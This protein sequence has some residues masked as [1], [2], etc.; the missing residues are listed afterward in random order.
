[1]DLASTTCSKM[2]RKKSKITQMIGCQKTRRVDC[3][4]SNRGDQTPEWEDDFD[5]S[6]HERTFF[7]TDQQ[8]KQTNGKGGGKQ[9][10]SFI[11]G[12]VPLCLRNTE[13]NVGSGS[14]ERWR[15]KAKS[16]IEVRHT[17]S[18]TK[19]ETGWWKTSLLSSCYRRI[20]G[21]WPQVTK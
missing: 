12:D 16:E 17:S 10:L 4:Q 1:M 7:Y 15:R 3:A 6:S 14:K 21:H 19:F 18:S 11:D 8:E 20:R 13:A 9:I 5:S 2:W